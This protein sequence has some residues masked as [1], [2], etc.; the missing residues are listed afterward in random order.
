MSHY[1]VV[2]GEEDFAFYQEHYEKAFTDKETLCAMVKRN[3][4][5][6]KG[7]IEQESIKDVPIGNS[8]VLGNPKAPIT[9][10]KWTDFQ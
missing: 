7:F 6:K 10:I 5:I 8:M 9:I 1:F 4:K 2:S 3:L